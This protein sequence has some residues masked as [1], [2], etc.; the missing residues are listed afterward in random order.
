MTKGAFPNDGVVHLVVH[1]CGQFRGR[2]RTGRPVGA[3][4]AQS[5]RDCRALVANGTTAS[6]LR[7]VYGRDLGSPARDDLAA[8]PDDRLEL[9]AQREAPAPG[10][11]GGGA[12]LACGLA[13]TAARRSSRRR[14][15]PTGN[16]PTAQPR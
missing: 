16:A 8:K 14:P 9:P 12:P 7:G 15:D 5:G 2:Q 11:R 10:H 13:V 3:S 6:V 4:A 1:T